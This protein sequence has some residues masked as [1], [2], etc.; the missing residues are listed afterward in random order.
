MAFP[1]TVE[2]KSSCLL[3][4]LPVPVAPSRL[5]LT[6]QP[7][8]VA[9]ILACTVAAQDKNKDGKSGKSDKSA[10]TQEQGDKTKPSDK[11]TDKSEKKAAAPKTVLPP[12]V[13]LLA[14]EFSR[15]WKFVAG[16]E[17]FQPEDVW[18]L[19][20]SE[21]GR[22]LMCLGKPKGYL[23][24]LAKHREY[25]LSF[26]FRF[27]IDANGSGGVLTH[28]DGTDKI[29]P[30]AFLVQLHR[31]VAGSVFPIGSRKSPY[32]IGARVPLGPVKQWNACI[33]EARGDTLKVTINGQSIGPFPGLCREAAFGHIGF[34][35]AGFEVHFRRIQVQSLVPVTPEP[36]GETRTAEVKKP[37]ETP[38]KDP[39]PEKGDE[40]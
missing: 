10:K 32:T 7:L 26:E 5:L 3:Q 15:T 2:S 37:G 1:P 21:Q 4:S 9:L 38:V 14:G 19:A 35:S 6:L 25:R 11:K 33:I 36:P 22:Y 27:P 39:T 20:D 40:G 17:G 18:K 16:E 29:W 28:V 30:D 34:Q 12:P 8:A 24:T 31:P 13:D 23:R